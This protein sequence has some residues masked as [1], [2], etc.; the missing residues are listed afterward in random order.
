VNVSNEL[1]IRGG[2]VVD[3]TGAPAFT[4]DVAIR[5]GRIVEI[6]EI[7]GNSRPELDASGCWVTPGF[8]DPHT[9]LDAQ[10]CWDPSASPTCFHGVTTVALGLCGFGVAPCPEQG[11]DYL[12]RS[13]EVVEEIPFASTSVGVPFEWTAW[14]EYWAFI[15]KQPLGVNVTGFVPH[16]ALRYFVMGERARGETATAEEREAMAAELTRAIAAGALG[17]ASSRGPNHVDSYGDPVPSRF[18]DAAELECL[19]AACAGRIWQVNVETKFSHDADKLLAELDTY[20]GWS[21]RHGARLTWSPLHAEPGDGVWQ[22]VLAHN[23]AANQTGVVV[24]P[25]V[26]PLP[27]SL[28]LRFDEAALVQQLLGL[29]SILAGFFDKSNED[30]LRFLSQASTREALRDARPH[31]KLPIQVRLADCAFLHTPS[32]PDLGGAN[33]GE[34]AAAQGIHPADLLCDQVI[35]DGLAT[36]VDVPVA[37]GSLEGRVR[38][39]QDPHTLMALGDSGAHVMSTT[40]YRYPT[41]LLSELVRDRELLDVELAIAHLTR[42]P[43]RLLGLRDRGELRPGAVADVCVIDRD[44]IGLE[45]VSIRYDLP[46]DAPRLYHPGRGYRAV[47]IGGIATIREDEP[48]G[49]ALGT[50]LSP[51]I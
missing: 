38:F 18:A 39:L 41:Y 27:L 37:N 42:R 3:G 45:P 22:R 2:T 36:L 46:G 14:S 51:S 25:Q 20:I 47:L 50:T 44:R 7:A 49:A 30:R 8:I 10:L 4:G 11:S 33:L 9:H 43:A 24:A 29:G 12:L 16:S 48:T 6:G 35:A 34:A 17:L 26:A 40:Q 15:A 1:V 5:D 28:L 21:R 23:Q 31:P 19:V 32:R 13:L